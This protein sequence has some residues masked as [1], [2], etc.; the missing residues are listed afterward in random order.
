MRAAL[1]GVRPR[2]SRRDPQ[3]ALLE[4]CGQL[5]ANTADLD[6]YGAR[7][8][9]RSD[10]FAAA[11]AYAGFRPWDGHEAATLGHGEPVID[12]VALIDERFRGHDRRACKIYG[13]LGERP[14]TAFEI[15]QKL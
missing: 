11:R 3:P 10:Q 6:G 2:R 8:Q 13:L 9:T 4:L 15:A 14:L 7:G 1:A 12:H 5:E